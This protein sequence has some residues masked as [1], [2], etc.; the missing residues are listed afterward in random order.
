M[1]VSTICSLLFAGV[2][3]AAPS[4]TVKT[5]R[6]LA[7]FQSAFAAVSTAI[8]TF[9][10]DIKALT[11][12]T[13]VNSV[14]PQLTTDSN[15]IVTA[16]DNGVTTVNAQPALSLLDSVSLLSLSSTLATNANNTVNDL[17]SA[18]PE[19]D[20]AG[21][22]GFVVTQLTSVKTASQ[23]FIAAVVAKVPTSVQSVANTQASNVI[24]ALNRGITAFGG[25]AS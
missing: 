19:I 25:T 10:T 16:L 12:S 17:I 6:D 23:S 14:L 2:A 1:R 15:A 24:T 8:N 3:L 9:D 11:P 22:D 21:E 13:D 5:K 20:A 7:A 4:K 18:K